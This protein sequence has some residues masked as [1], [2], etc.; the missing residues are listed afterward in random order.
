MSGGGHSSQVALAPAICPGAIGL[1]VFVLVAS[2]A[3][4]DLPGAG[5]K[6]PQQVVVVVLV[7]KGGP[8][9]TSAPPPQ[10]EFP[11]PTSKDPWPST[12]F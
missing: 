4:L 2:R 3:V 6:A 10:R 8:T 7:T 12:A 1:G 11:V 5:L 9:S